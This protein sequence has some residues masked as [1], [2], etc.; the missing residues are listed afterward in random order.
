MRPKARAYTHQGH[1]PRADQTGRIHIS[2]FR[3]P[4]T[5]LLA[6]SSRSI[7]LG[8]KRPSA[9]VA[10]HRNQPVPDETEHETPRFSLMTIPME[11]Q[12]AREDFEAFLDEAKDALDF[13]TRNP[14]Y[15]T[16]Q[17]VLLAFRRR[18]TAEQILMFAA[19]L[20]PVLRAIFVA[21]WTPG[22]H[23]ASFPAREKLAEE[24]QHL[25]RNHNFSPDN[26]IAIVARVLR[27]HVDEAAFERLLSALPLGSHEF[28]R[29]ER[30]D[31]PLC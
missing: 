25:R 31:G 23:V 17:G 19:L 10:S 13:T 24:V 30:R 3:F 20:P 11:Y 8:Q 16:V 22:E 27:R 26:S 2:D 29:V 14:T 1:G 18:L 21:D 28:W 5:N 15:T 6:I 4:R 9:L 12:R 7:H